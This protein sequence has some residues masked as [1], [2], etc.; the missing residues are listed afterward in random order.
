MGFEAKV[1]SKGQITLPARLREKLGI[2]PGDRV[3]FVEGPDGSI[4]M[5]RKTASFND[6]RGMIKLAEP[7]TPDQI[8]AWVAE[9]R[10]K[11]GTRS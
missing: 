1:T 9:A 11:I 7:V 2:L 8:L 6:L 4:S 3:E 10:T 5:L